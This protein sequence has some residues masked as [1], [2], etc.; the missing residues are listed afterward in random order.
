MRGWHSGTPGAGLKSKFWAK[1]APALYFYFA[2]FIAFAY[3]GAEK[4]I[5]REI[6]AKAHA[7]LIDEL[8]AQI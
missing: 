3:A 6:D 2:L 5:R 4:L 7:A 1:M 8:A